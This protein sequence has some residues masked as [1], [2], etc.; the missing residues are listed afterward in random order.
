MAVNAIQQG[1][2]SYG[3]QGTDGDVGAFVF[4]TIPYQGTATV[5]L[6][7]S[8]AV[9]P[10]R[11]VVKSITFVPDVISA[12]AVTA[13]LYKAPSGTAIGSGTALHTG[14]ANLQGTA[15]TTQ[16]L[17]LSTTSGV[18]DVAA[19]NRLGVVISG[20]P[21]ATGNGVFTIALCPA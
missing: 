10:R 17:T 7:I 5:G 20:A 1:D 2:A 14:T 19:G 8:A 13:T 4:V 3:L 6:A 21:G 11:C 18:L 15:A 16:T 9:L 12:N